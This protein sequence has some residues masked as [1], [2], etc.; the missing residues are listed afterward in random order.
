LL[1]PF[2]S[3]RDLPAE[4]TGASTIYERQLQEKQQFY[5]EIER[6]KKEKEEMELR[7]LSFKP[8][9]NINSKK[10][11]EKKLSTNS[12]GA[13]GGSSASDVVSRLTAP[14]PTKPRNHRRTASPFAGD[15][16]SVAS[17]TKVH[18]GPH[19][20]YQSEEE[21]ESGEGGGKLKP[22]KS[23]IM[24]E[25]E[26]SSL[27]SRLSSKSEDPHGSSY[28]HSQK[29]ENHEEENEEIDENGK[30]ILKKKRKSLLDMKV[31][32]KDMNSIVDR[33]SHSHTESSL[34]RSLTKEDVLDSTINLSRDHY[35]YPNSLHNS[36]NLNNTGGSSHSNGNEEEKGQQQHS[37]AEQHPGY[38]TSDHVSGNYHLHQ[39]I[40]SSSSPQKKSNRTIISPSPITSFSPLKSTPSKQE[41]THQQQQHQTNETT[42]HLPKL[43]KG[44]K[45]RVV[46]HGKKGSY[47]YGKVTH[48]FNDGTY[49]I[50]YEN[51][52][53]GF[54]IKR[55]LIELVKACHKSSFAQKKIKHGK[56]ETQDPTGTTEN[57]EDAVLDGMSK[58]FVLSPKNKF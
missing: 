46:Y 35:R 6:K 45:V 34:H 51:N 11:I 2:F 37:A 44:D 27:F 23:I 38:L 9:L 43:C 53:K 17:S 29:P 8:S 24:S 19:H 16:T 39:T 30:K 52:H 31:S 26:L 58:S 10:L 49:D 55:E 33:L 20:H 21:R 36:V 28:L 54:R 47:L 32:S 56:K 4:A 22:R 41:Q 15:D 5:E 14:S 50:D 7:G 40:K 48:D 18:G 57:G 1:F 25:K 3:F 13:T 12:M 42:S